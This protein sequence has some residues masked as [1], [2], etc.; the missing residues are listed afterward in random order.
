MH[1]EEGKLFDAVFY[2]LLSLGVA[3][4]AAAA[5]VWF[6]WATARM[7]AITRDASPPETPADAN[8]MSQQAPGETPSADAMIKLFLCPMA[9]AAGRL[10]RLPHGL[11]ETTA[12]AVFFAGGPS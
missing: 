9:R 7:G 11:A 3:L 10:E 8:S 4:I 5:I 2:K 1:N 12:D 6:I